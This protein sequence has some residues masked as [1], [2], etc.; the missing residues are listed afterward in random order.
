MPTRLGLCKLRR[1][2]HVKLGTF[3]IRI[4]GIQYRNWPHAAKLTILALSPPPSQRMDSARRVDSGGLFLGIFATVQRKNLRSLPM[5]VSLSSL[6]R[7]AKPG[8]C[9]KIMRANT[10]FAYLRWH[11]IGQASKWL[12]G[13]LQNVYIPLYQQRRGKPAIDQIT[14]QE[15]SGG[16]DAK[17]PGKCWKGPR[18][19]PLRTIGMT[20]TPLSRLAIPHAAGGGALPRALVVAGVRHMPGAGGSLR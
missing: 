17:P 13:Y 19:W 14:A 7:S 4:S 16:V 12:L 6:V 20:T 18:R 10:G 11:I 1:S 9:A 3:F 15:W 2:F 5:R 8:F